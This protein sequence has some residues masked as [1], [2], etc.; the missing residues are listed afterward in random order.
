MF[1]I[2]VCDVAIYKCYL[3][4]LYLAKHQAI[5]FGYKILLSKF[6]S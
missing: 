3:I 2:K 4:D 1:I 5:I 6:C